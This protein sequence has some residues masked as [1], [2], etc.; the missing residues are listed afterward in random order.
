MKKEFLKQML[1]GVLEAEE[2]DGLMLVN[3]IGMGGDDIVPEHVSSEDPVCN[4]EE[5]DDDSSD[6]QSSREEGSDT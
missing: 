3:T 2:L 4:E 1:G 6:Q 5:D